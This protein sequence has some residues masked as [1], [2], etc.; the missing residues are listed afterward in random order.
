MITSWTLVVRLQLFQTKGKC[1]ENT[2]L[3]STSPARMLGVSSTSP[4]AAD[5]RWGRRK[6]PQQVPGKSDGHARRRPGLTSAANCVLAER[7]G[8][9]PQQGQGGP[10]ERAGGRAAGSHPGRPRRRLG[11]LTCHPSRHLWRQRCACGHGLGGGT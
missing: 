5:L 4:P 3:F 6:R 1:T 9:R 2:W 8:G 11:P 7:A 10:G